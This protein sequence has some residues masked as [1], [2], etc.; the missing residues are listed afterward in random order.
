MPKLLKQYIKVVQQTVF[1]IHSSI[2]CLPGLQ[3]VVSERE[4]EGRNAQEQSSRLQTELTRLRQELQDKA[5]QEETLRQ[6][7]T[8]KEEKTKK[9][10]VLA[11]Q[12]IS[13]LI[14]ET[15]SHNTTDAPKLKSLLSLCSSPHIV[16]QAQICHAQCTYL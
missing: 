9:A 13:Q 1:C 11:K 5:S 10:F 6:Q 3:Q 2:S 7:L 14:G 4:T 8:E 12:K 15:V 16:I